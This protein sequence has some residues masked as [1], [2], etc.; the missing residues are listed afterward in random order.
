MEETTTG[1]VSDNSSLKI[2]YIL[3]LVGTLGFMVYLGINFD[4]YSE[5]ELMESSYY[6]VPGLG[7]S[8]IGLLS[9]RSSKSII[10]ALIGG[11]AAFVLLWVFFESLWPML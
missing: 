7:F 1:V 2:L 3:A 8:L 4:N 6:F 5:E 9:N 11:V 10:Y